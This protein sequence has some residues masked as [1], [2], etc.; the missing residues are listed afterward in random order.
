MRIYHLLCWTLDLCLPHQTYLNLFALP[1]QSYKKGNK[2]Y[3]EVCILFP[4]NSLA[5]YPLRY[6]LVFWHF[7]QV[8]LVFVLVFAD[9]LDGITDVL[10]IELTDFS[11]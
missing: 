2:L 3:T 11:K 10:S 5:S 1:R 6:P 9:I 8:T 4:S 7:R